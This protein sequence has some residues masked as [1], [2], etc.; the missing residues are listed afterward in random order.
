MASTLLLKLS[1]LAL[2]LV[3]C[4]AAIASDPPLPTP[5]EIK[6]RFDTALQ[7]AKAKRERETLS[8]MGCFRDVDLATKAAEKLG[9]K[10]ILWV[11]LKCE[12]YPELRKEFADCIHCHA[13]TFGGDSTPRIVVTASDGKQYRVEKTDLSVS[14]VKHALG[15]S[16]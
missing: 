3:G 6:G 16:R 14:A 15:E 2:L 7:L 1:C 11:G 12:S 4:S 5:A 13:D 10:L 8:A 9:K